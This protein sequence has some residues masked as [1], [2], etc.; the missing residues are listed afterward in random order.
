LRTQDVG[1]QEN[2]G[3]MDRTIHV[4]FRGEMDDT[5]YVMLA[6]NFLH[7]YR[8]T[9]I[10]LHEN[11]SRILQYPF[12]VLQVPGIREFI[13]TDNLPIPVVS[14]KERN[15]ITSD[16]TRTTRDKNIHIFSSSNV[17]VGRPSYPFRFLKTLSNSEKTR[18]RE[19]FISLRKSKRITDNPRKALPISTPRPFWGIP[20]LLPQYSTR[21]SEADSTKS[22]LG[23]MVQSEF[24]WHP[25]R[26]MQGR[27]SLSA[28]FPLPGNRIELR[29]AVFSKK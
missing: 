6:E 18:S 24:I 9:N 21:I 8:I 16:E 13:Q 26:F 2:L 3:I 27:A 4:G 12:Q 17:A 11:K 7:Q 15:E 10:S 22:F 29:K 28:H 25:Y 14:K 5:I 23:E 1:S 19:I 20:F